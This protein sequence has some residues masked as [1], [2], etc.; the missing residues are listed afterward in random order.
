MLSVDEEKTDNEVA[1]L[2]V[3]KEKTDKEVV[4]LSVD[5][6]KTDKEVAMLLLVVHSLL[7]PACKNQGPLVELTYWVQLLPN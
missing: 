5:K 2:S 6:E 7:P 3:D 1:M 4:M